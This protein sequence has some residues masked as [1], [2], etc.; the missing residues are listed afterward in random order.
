MEDPST[1]P[2]SERIFHANASRFHGASKKSALCNFSR[3]TPTRALADII[4]SL[5]VPDLCI[6]VDGM[7]A[8]Q[9]M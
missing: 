5:G 2:H 6:Q 4:Y 3:E 1:W 9:I 8:P 7:L